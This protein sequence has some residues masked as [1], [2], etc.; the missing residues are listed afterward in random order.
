MPVDSE[1]DL[2]LLTCEMCLLSRNC[3]TGLK[4]TQ[5]KTGGEVVG[6]KAPEAEADN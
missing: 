6:N 4:L 2:K 3:K 1:D 5:T